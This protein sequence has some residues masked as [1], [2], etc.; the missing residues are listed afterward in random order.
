MDLNKSTLRKYFFNLFIVGLFLWGVFSL[1]YI[2]RFRK[3]HVMTSNNYKEDIAQLKEREEH[4]LGELE[5]LKMQ[6]VS[7]SECNTNIASLDYSFFLEAQE[8]GL[9]H[10]QTDIPP[11]IV[12]AG[13]IY[14]T[15]K[16]DSIP[17]QTL[18]DALPELERLKPDL[19][20]SLGDMTYMPSAQSFHVLENSFLSKVEFPFIN[21]PG[22]HDL[23]QGR[24]LYE[25]YFGQT[26]FYT[27]YLPAQII[28]L[29]TELANCQIVGRQ[30]EM[31]EEALNLGLQD[32][33]IKY[34]FVFMHKVL[35]LDQ[36]ESLWNRVNGICSFGNNYNE[37]LDEL[38]LPASSEKDIYLF[39]G[40]VGAFGGNLSPFYEQDEN[41]ERKRL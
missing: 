22:N 34:I 35:F 16:S 41:H 38:L 39:A 28:V 1:G 10:I 18:I 36:N 30:K 17:A 40:D 29:D 24:E 21:A 23:G 31:L 11:R 32:E 26:F 8:I 13:H 9:N 6:I 19:F 20:V 3:V 15:R 7:Q 2:Y 4:L 5:K 12:V 14:G 27:R 37:I 25:E 33:E